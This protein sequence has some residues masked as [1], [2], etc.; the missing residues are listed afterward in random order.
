M[1]WMI[2]QTVLWFVAHFVF[3]V[4]KSMCRYDVLI[5]IKYCVP[6]QLFDKLSSHS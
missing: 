3:E 2:T 6:F 1:D 4:K 5:L